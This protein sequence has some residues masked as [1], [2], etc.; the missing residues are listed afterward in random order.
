MSAAP[1]A[2]WRGFHLF[3]HGDRDRVVEGFVR[4]VAASL[5]AEGRARRFFF[6]RYALGGPHV[7]LRLEVGE[8]DPSESAETEARV[9]RAA[10]AFLACH[11]SPEPLPEGRVREQNREL[12]ASDP[13]AGPDDDV[14]FPDNSLAGHPVRFEVARYG[15]PALLDASLDLFAVSSL[16]ALGFVTGAEGRPPRRRPAEVLRLLLAQAWP[17]ARDAEELSA[18]AEYGVRMFGRPLSGLLPVADAA[19]ERSRAA[20]CALVRGEVAAFSGPGGGPP[21]AE[22][23]RALAWTVR[24]APDEARRTLSAAQVHMTANRLGLANAD[25]VYL[26]RMLSRALAASAEDDPAFWRAAWEARAEWS[27]VS[28]VLLRDQAAAALA[29]LA[30]F[31]AAETAVAMV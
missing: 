27:A 11:P 25:E 2:G 24:E 4:P 18:L 17:L 7:R 10:E 16:V 14:V 6:V 22:A 23:S 15:G 30:A 5:L 12:I 26:S 13:F 28:P 3:H 9:R 1:E 29:A 31:A 21:L 19:F 20:L 8:E